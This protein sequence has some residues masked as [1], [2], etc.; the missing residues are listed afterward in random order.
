MRKGEIFMPIFTI[1]LLILMSTFIFLIYSHQKNTQEFFSIG[2]IQSNIIK[3]YLESEKIFFYYEKLLEYNEYKAVKEFSEDGAVMKSCKKRWKFNS[4]C[5]PEFENY[6]KE[7]LIKK[8]G[9]KYRELKVNQEV[10]V[11]FTDFIF[12]PKSK[13]T[14]VNYDGS[15]IIKKQSLINFNDLKSLKVKIKDCIQ[16][17]D[18]NKCSPESNAGSIYKFKHKIA[19]ILDKDLKKEEVY[20]EF[21]VDTK[22]SGLVTSIF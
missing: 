17:K 8:L 11:Y 1:G 18:I 2:L 20:L 12:S 3:D 22:D 10:E 21:E 19:E 9:N 7:L 14:E 5:E 16:S 13:T 6:F 4:E 15:V